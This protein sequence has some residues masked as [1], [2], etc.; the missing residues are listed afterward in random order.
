MSNGGIDADF[1]R[2]NSLFSFQCILSIKRFIPSVFYLFILAVFSIY[3]SGDW[4]WAKARDWFFNRNGNIRDT[5][6]V[7]D[8]YIRVLMV[9]CQ[10]IDK[11]RKY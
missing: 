8:W 6:R 9:N 1:I 7:F 10:K 11:F 4:N 2:T 3:N 5:T